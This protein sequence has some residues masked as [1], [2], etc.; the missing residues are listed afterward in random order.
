DS[1][2]IKR[3][4]NVKRRAFLLP[5]VG[6]L[7]LEAAHDLLLEHAVLIVNAIA[8]AGHAESGHG[9]QKAGS[10]TSQ[11]AIA[12]ARVRLHFQNILQIDAELRQHSAAGLHQAQ[13]AE[14]VAQPTAH[15]EFHG[16]I[17]E[18]L[19]LLVAIALLGLEQSIH[20]QIANGERDGLEQ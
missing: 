8:E 17:T 19:E 13:V 1:G 6:L 2:D 16:E 9:F 5:L 15:Q 12:Q 4:L 10:Q 18:T 20:Q 14:I 7:P 11:A 3:A